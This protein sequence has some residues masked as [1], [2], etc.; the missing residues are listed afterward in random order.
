MNDEIHGRAKG[1]IAR[2]EALS[3]ER[4]SEIARK[5]AENRWKHPRGKNINNNKGLSV[6]RLSKPRSPDQYRR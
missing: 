3:S 1:G 6:I 4:R 5:A 2:A